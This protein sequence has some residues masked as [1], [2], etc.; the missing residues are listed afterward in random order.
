MMI[1]YLVPERV[2][3][4]GEGMGVA[5]LKI[6]LFIAVIIFFYKSRRPQF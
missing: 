2:G 1:L 5:P 3:G 4:G 6:V